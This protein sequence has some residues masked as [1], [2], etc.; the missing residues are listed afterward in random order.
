MGMTEEQNQML[1]S[2][3]K[4]LPQVGISVTAVK[5]DSLPSGATVIHPKP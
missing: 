2:A 4:S 3:P 1:S 5:K